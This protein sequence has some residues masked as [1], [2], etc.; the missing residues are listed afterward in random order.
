[1]SAKLVEPQ[2]ELCKYLGIEMVP[3]ICDDIS[4]DS[5]YYIKEKYIVLSPICLNHIL[6]L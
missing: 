5:K 2:M 1:M 4:D 6:M 3:V